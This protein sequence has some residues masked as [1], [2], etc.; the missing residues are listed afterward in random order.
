MESDTVQNGVTAATHEVE[1]AFKAR[2]AMSVA[3]P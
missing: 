3:D 2:D 1:W